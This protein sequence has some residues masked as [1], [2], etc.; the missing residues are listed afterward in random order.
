MTTYA[1]T[2]PLH[3]VIALAVEPQPV[4]APVSRGA[5]MTGRETRLLEALLS[6]EGSHRSTATDA[7]WSRALAKIAAKH[8]GPYLAHGERY[9]VRA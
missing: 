1:D 8:L 3:V 7:G 6:D 9:A 2:N 4:A 5:L